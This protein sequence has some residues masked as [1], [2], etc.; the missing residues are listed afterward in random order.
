[1]RENKNINSREQVLAAAQRQE[2]LEAGAQ[3]M[4]PRRRIEQAPSMRSLSDTQQVRRPFTITKESKPEDTT[5]QAGSGPPLKQTSLCHRCKRPGHKAFEYDK[6]PES[7]KNTQQAGV[8]H[9]PITD[10]ARAKN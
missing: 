5:R 4:V 10:D 6:C 7:R 2:E 8:A 9:T 3:R 1:M